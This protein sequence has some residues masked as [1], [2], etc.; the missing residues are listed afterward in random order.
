MGRTFWKPIGIYH[1]VNSDEDGSGM[2][3]ILVTNSTPAA[4]TD[5][6]NFQ[7]QMRSGNNSGVIKPNVI[8]YYDQGSGMV[9]VEDGSDALVTGDEISI[10]GMFAMITTPSNGKE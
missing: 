7:V 10:I 3:R 1:T 6:F 4:A 8:A 5:K 2:A 9:H